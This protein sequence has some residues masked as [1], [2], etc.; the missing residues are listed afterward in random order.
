M[1]KMTSGQVLTLKCGLHVPIIR[2]NLVSAAPLIRNEF[3]CVLVSD[4]TEISKN[5]IFLG[6][7]Y[8][9]EGLFKMNLMVVDNI[10][11]NCASVYLLKSNDL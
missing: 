9:S 4:N 2:K 6:K 1:L 5:E 8:I 10:N 11:K 3:K 7:S